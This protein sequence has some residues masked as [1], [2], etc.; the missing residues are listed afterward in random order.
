MT[1]LLE[2]IGIQGAVPGFL[3]RGFVCIK[4]WEVRFADFISFFRNIP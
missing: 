4:V 2:D 3:E 1:S